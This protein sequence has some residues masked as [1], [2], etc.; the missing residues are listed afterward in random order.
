MDECDLVSTP[1]PPTHTPQRVKII[2]H[3][4]FRAII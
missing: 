1:P 4:I 3:L 2:E